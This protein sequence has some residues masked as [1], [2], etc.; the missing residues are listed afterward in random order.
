MIMA[1]YYTP[2]LKEKNITISY[3]YL[4]CVTSYTYASQLEIKLSVL[5]RKLP[6]GHW[7]YGRFAGA[8][9]SLP[10]VHKCYICAGLLERYDQ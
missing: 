9:I 3:K 6:G 7:P 1:N 8:S 4:F 2:N 5:R 10:F